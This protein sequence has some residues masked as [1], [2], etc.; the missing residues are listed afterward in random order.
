MPDRAPRSLPLVGVL[1]LDTAFPRPPGDIGNAA[2]FGGR[3]LYETV[4]AAG[5][6]SVLSGDPDDPALAQAFLG[7]R[8][9]L[10]ARGAQILTTSCGLL[11]FQQARLS[12]DCPVPFTA[13]ALF[14]VPLRRAQHGRV[15]VMAL[16]PGSLG[17]RHLVAAG[18]GRDVPVAALPDDAHLLSVLRANR[19]DIPIDPAHAEAE[20]VAAGR[21]LL[22]QAPDLGAVVLEC[23]NLPPYAAALEAAIGRPVFGFLDW[24]AEVAEGH[25][26]PDGRIPAANPTGH[27][28]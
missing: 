24:L 18:V 10:V 28:R 13:S 11:V 19:P 9:R 5:I 25:A 17:P 1:M 21:R 15:G 16:A 20:V 22:D 8:D 4:P 26:L 12:R 23:T 7:A 6:D 2:T 3:V 27:S 14:Q